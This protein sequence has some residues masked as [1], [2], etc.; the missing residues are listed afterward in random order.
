MSMKSTADRYGSIPLTLHWLS[1]GLILALIPMGFAMQGATGDVRL[2]LYRAHAM[3]GGLTGL[4]TL[5]RLVWWVVFDRKPKASRGASALQRLLA[6]TVHAGLYGIVL[7]LALSGIGLVATSGLSAALLTGDASLIPA[8]LS[9][10]PPRL[11]HGLMARLLVG[12]LILHVL[13][14]LYHHWIKRD[15]T[16][17]RMLPQVR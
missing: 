14:A 9:D 8:D 7:V 6:K 5:M 15:G 2:G 3:A 11:A 13:G 12:L 1:A 4:L 17:G 16:L 10:L